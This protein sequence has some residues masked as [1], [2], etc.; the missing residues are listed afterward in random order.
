MFSRIALAHPGSPSDLPLGNKIVYD[1]PP[2]PWYAR[3][4]RPFFGRELAE[5]LLWVEGRSSMPCSSGSTLLIRPTA[6]RVRR[7]S[8]FSS[9]ADTYVT[10]R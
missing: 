9:G 3:P 8:S 4:D 6:A 7:G 1:L 10:A 5:S 2:V